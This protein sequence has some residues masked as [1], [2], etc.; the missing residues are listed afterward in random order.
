MRR[1]KPEELPALLNQGVKVVDVRP[2]DKRHTPLPFPAEWVPLEKIQ[3]GE[4]HLP[5]VPLLLV[6]EKGLISQVAALYLEA[7]GYE[8]MSL[9]GGL[10]ALTEGS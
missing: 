1:V 6:C 2:A 3:A 4:H 5:K 9:E 10:Q 8:A 7:E